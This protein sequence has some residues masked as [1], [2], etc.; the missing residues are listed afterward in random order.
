MQE[1]LM[2]SFL[3]VAGLNIGAQLTTSIAARTSP[4]K[5]KKKIS[6]WSVKTHRKLIVKSEIAGVLL[7]VALV[8]LSL[9]V[10]RI[11]QRNTSERIEK[12]LTRIPLNRN[13]SEIEISYTPSQKKWDEI[14]RAYSKIKSPESDLPYANASMK[15][16]SDGDYWKIDFE[17][18]AVPDGYKKLHRLSTKDNPLFVAVLKEALIGLRILWGNGTETT[19]SPDQAYYPSALFVSRQKVSFILRPPLVVWSLNELYDNPVVTF[20]GKDYPIELP[21]TFTVHSLDPG[22]ALEQTIELG[23]LK[24]TASEPSKKPSDI[25]DLYMNRQ[26]SGPHRLLVKFAVFDPR[27]GRQY[28]PPGN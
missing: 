2:Y 12:A 27:S 20:F 4:R 23:W 26:K 9:F 19:V 22:V 16:E 8:V 28:V 14:A 24:R 18:T 6:W 21:E 5:I 13:L 3:I 25:F 11:T 15:A 10:Q 17:P 7:A 1:I